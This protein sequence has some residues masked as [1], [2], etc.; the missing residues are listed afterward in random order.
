MSPMPVRAIFSAACLLCTAAPLGVFAGTEP[1][2]TVIGTR[3]AEIT[4]PGSGQVL[5]REQLDR[6]RVFTINE[7]LRQ[8][9][10]VY[11]R[12]EEGMGLRP[13]IGIRGLNPTRSGK[14]L[15]LEDGLPLAYGP[16]GENTSY[17]HPPV[18]RFARIEVLKGSGQIEFGPQTIAGVINYV[19]PS[20]PAE[21]ASELTVSGGN[22]GY[23][24]LHL[25]SGNTF[26]DTGVL[27]N[28]TRKDSD[29]SRDN[30]NFEVS[31][32][33]LKLVQRLSDTQRLSFK[34]SYY[35]EDSRVPYS[36]LTLAEYQADPRANV[37][38]NDRFNLYRWSAVLTHELQLNARAQLTTSAYYSYFNRNWWR[39]SSNSNQRPNDASDPDCGSLVNLQ[40]TCGNEGRL[41]QY[42]TGGVEPRLRVAS[43]WFGS[44]QQTDLGLR[45]HRE[46]H[47][48]V[49][50]NGDFPT[51]REPG[52]GPNAGVRENS[53]R[54]VE[55]RAAFWQ[56][57]FEL[58][59]V[60]L[61]P[62]VRVESVDY[63]RR[64]LASG[65]R[66]DSSLT[67][68]IPGL[69]A[70]FEPVDGTL[71][72][73]GAHRGFAPP[74]VA[75][76]VTAAGG[77]V[78]LD[79]ELSWNYEFGVRSRL[80]PGVDVEATLFRLDFE[81]QIIPASLAG[82]SGATLTSAGETLHAGA[83]LLLRLSSRGLF[84]SADDYYLR[85]S[86]TR[87]Q[88]AQF[89]GERFS[90]ITPAARVTGNRLPYAPED[91]L[92]L[93][94]GAELRNGFGLQLE[95]IHNG[96]MFSDDLNTVAITAN[97]QRG[98][99]P[100]HSIWNLTA[101]YELAPRGLTLFATAKNLTD[102]LYIADLSRG[103]IPG[104]PRLLQAG[105]ELRF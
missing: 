3:D 17:Y 105:F 29:G 55:A 84:D 9:P 23:R 96:S 1:T 24:E 12:D 74:G 31:D 25:E 97:G 36:G 39:Q 41:R 11:P 78:E 34:T 87:L 100:G 76:V 46:Q 69:G 88:H 15:L 80:R 21:F 60:S 42:G 86:Y 32:A 57:R 89:R 90:A 53:E 35:R 40:S 72:F 7:A 66:G 14:V 44:A 67:Q 38:T 64:E 61:T 54:E 2:I 93:S 63:S 6:S 71:F 82:G 19:T 104:S 48:R 59:R 20:P 10:G 75:D 95:L 5:D 79:A 77:S 33:N 51:A 98:Q 83:E 22:R 28:L 65:L 8:I 102:G 92:S 101:Q 26:G 27:V 94:L 103:L 81:N 52:I 37:F 45:W 68:W 99:I 49:Q 58:G 47:Y 91:L 62:G 4:S 70:T 73:V 50:V 13:N 16:Y 30:M 85:A 56:T 18:D 43:N